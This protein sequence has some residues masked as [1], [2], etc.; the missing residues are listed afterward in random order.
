MKPDEGTASPDTE[1]LP[2]P[3]M[4]IGSKRDVIRRVVSPKEMDRYCRDAIMGTTGIDIDHP[5]EG[6]KPDAERFRMTIEHLCRD[7]HERI[8]WGL[9]N[10]WGELQRVTEIREIERLGEEDHEI[11][12]KLF[13]HG[14]KHEPHVFGDKYEDQVVKTPDQVK[15]WIRNNHAVGIKFNYKDQEGATKERLA[16]IAFLRTGEGAQSHIGYVGRLYVHP[17]HR[18]RNL[19]RDVLLHLLDHAE[20]T[21]IEQIE[22]WVTTTNTSAME[23]Y[24]K[25]GFRKS[26]NTRVGAVIISGT[27]YD[28][29]PILL[30]MDEYRKRRPDL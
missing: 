27:A 22:G 10:G 5:L 25:I 11:F 18:R 20:E 28:W 21:G 6:Q 14:L 3:K 12:Q 9:Y 19:S 24:K 2:V 29:D 23:F 30:I 16:A 4:G 17:A 7:I 13:L 26:G 15:E 1:N 8:H